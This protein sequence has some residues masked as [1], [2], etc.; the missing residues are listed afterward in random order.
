MTQANARIIFTKSHVKGPMHTVFTTPVASHRTCK[1]L[2]ARKTQKRVSGLLSACLAQA[3]FCLDH[4]DAACP[5]PPLLGVQIGEVVWIGKGPIASDLQA[6]M[7]LLH[8]LM[9]LILHMSNQ[10][11]TK[12]NNRRISNGHLTIVE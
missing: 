8:R 6:A 2:S 12:R 9:K 7:S 5:F 4:P 10:R 3:A 1:R 11:S